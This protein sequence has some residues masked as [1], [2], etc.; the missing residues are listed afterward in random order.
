MSVIA[1]RPSCVRH[2]YM[3]LR[4]IERQT[5]EQRWCGVWYDCAAPHCMSSVLLP[6]GELAGDRPGDLTA[7][8]YDRL[9]GPPEPDEDGC[10]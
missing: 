6:T 3:E 8:D 9:F 7:D 5:P 1:E 4:P 10:E 2:G